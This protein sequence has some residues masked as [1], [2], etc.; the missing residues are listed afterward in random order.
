MNLHPAIH[1]LPTFITL[2]VLLLAGLS[3]CGPD[4]GSAAGPDA[5]ANAA[6]ASASAAHHATDFVEIEWTDLMPADDLNA[7]LN[8]PEY[9]LQVEDGSAADQ[10]GDPLRLDPQNRPADRYQQALTS[11]A[12]RPEFAGRPVKLAGF[13]VP[14]AFKT[15]SGT[16]AAE[17]P[18][19]LAAFTSGAAGADTL[20]TEFFL[21]PFFGACIHVPPPPPNQI[22]YARYE[23]GLHLASLYDPFWISG[24]LQV[25]TTA[26][27][28]ATSAY[29]IVIATI[30]PYSEDPAANDPWAEEDSGSAP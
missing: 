26:N 24:Q 25:A 10:I 20:V 23:P 15:G 13:I 11:A 19:A 8:P 7:L 2:G 14:L 12:V 21:V 6:S 28:T 1:S 17:G 30:E 16:A 3:G 9:V 5:A 29:S 22:I 4:T 18:A 27:A